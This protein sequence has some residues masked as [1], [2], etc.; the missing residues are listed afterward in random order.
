M[1]QAGFNPLTAILFTLDFFVSSLNVSNYYKLISRFLMKMKNYFF[2]FM[3]YF[4][5]YPNIKNIKLVEEELMIIKT[6]YVIKNIDI[7]I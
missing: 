7:Q 2:R 5:L 1:L 6:E 3:L 4:A